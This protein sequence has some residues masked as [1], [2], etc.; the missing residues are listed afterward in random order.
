MHVAVKMLA[1]AFADATGTAAD[2][3]FE[4]AKTLRHHDAPL[5]GYEI[6]H[7]QLAR[8]GE[9]DWLGVGIRRAEVY[10]TH[11]HGL[12]DN[13]DAFFH[14]AD[15]KYC[16]LGL[17]DNRRRDQAAAHAVVGDGESPALDLI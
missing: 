6:H 10:G 7:G 5:R 16:R 12:L 14:F 9:D 13:D 1:D 11:W 15:A 8:S 2:I 4:P 17:I 3:V